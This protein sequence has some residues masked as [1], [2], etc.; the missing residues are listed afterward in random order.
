[1]M[2]KCIVCSKEFIQNSGFQKYCKVCAKKIIRERNLNNYYKNIEKN[3][4]KHRLSAKKRY[5]PKPNSKYMNCV[6]CEDKFFGN[7]RAKLCELCRIKK[8]AYYC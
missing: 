3:R 7:V 4:E 2:K 8:R 1:M 6:V 5:K